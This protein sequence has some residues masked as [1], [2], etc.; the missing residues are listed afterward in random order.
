[1]E[2]ILRQ[3]TDKSFDEAWA[4]AQKCQNPDLRAFMLQSIIE[5]LAEK[6]PERAVTLEAEEKLANP[7]FR[8]AAVPV[9]QKSKLKVGA[10]EYVESIKRFPLER[11]SGGS[12]EEFADDFDFKLAA[13][14]ITALKKANKGKG[15]SSFPT[16]F[17]QEWAK[18]DPQAAFD[19]WA[20]NP[21]L[22][23]NDLNT[24]LAGIETNS[25][26]ATTA[27][28]VEKLQDPSV[29]RKKLVEELVSIDVE[30]LMPRV[31]SIASAMPDAR[32]AD[33][34][35]S[36]VFV[37]ESEGVVEAS[38]FALNSMSS[39]D[40]RLDALRAMAAKHENVEV[41]E[42]TDEQLQAWGITRQQAE[43]AIAK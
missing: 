10:A 34:F 19:W 25:P 11:T 39:P 42:V 2:K 7:Q 1:M 23:F 5:R 17:M 43:K 30:D 9:L 37:A 16:N 12:D 18:K 40:A 15:P 20:A 13:D 33:A 35:L 21:T 36:D 4:A 24:V 6:D 28:L 14:G 26:G 38:A 32:T 3:W 31:N 22:L 29:P 27:L 8:T 41:G